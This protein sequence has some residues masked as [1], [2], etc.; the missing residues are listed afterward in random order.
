VH[1]KEVV[2][3][4]IIMAG[5]KGGRM[6]GLGEK[7]LVKVGGVEMLRRVLKAL[8]DSK[9]VG[10]VIVA[11]SPHSPSTAKRARSLGLQV[12]TAPGEGYVED[13]R[14]II[15]KTQIEYAVVVNSDLPF[16]TGELIDKVVERFLLAK[17]P[18]LTVM[19]ST[20]EMKKLGLEPAYQ[21]A[22]LSPAGVNVLET[23]GL[24]KNGTDEET[25][26]MTDVLQLINVNTPSDVRKAEKLLVDVRAQGVNRAT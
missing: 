7:P 16:I 15:S 25:F 9:Y 8:Q 21:F 2:W 1:G 13:L 4:A 23:R 20:E 19:V 17:K 5:G 6:A 22:E 18:A 10:R 26:V 3:T 24:Y 14:C 12:V 11:C